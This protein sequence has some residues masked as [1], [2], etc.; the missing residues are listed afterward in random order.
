MRRFS[1]VNNDFTKFLKTKKSGGIKYAKIYIEDLRLHNGKVIGN[2]TILF[3]PDYHLWHYGTPYRKNIDHIQPICRAKEI[4]FERCDH[5]FITYALVH[6]MFPCVERFIFISSNMNLSRIRD[7][8]GVKLVT[9]DGSFDG[10]YYVGKQDICF[11]FI[12]HK[13]HDKLMSKLEEEPI[14]HI[15]NK[16]FVE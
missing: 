4:I 8:P 13:E 11:E 12:T 14:F 16:T 5:Y 1:K 9:N 7:F 2:N 10:S 3:C 6:K 15:H